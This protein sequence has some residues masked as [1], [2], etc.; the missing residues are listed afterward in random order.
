MKSR[1]VSAFLA[2]VLAA[3]AVFSAGEAHVVIMHTNDIRGHVLPSVE[4]G[5]SARLSTIVKDAKPDLMFDAGGM[6]AGSL[7]ADTFLGVPV[8]DVM[9]AIGYDAATVG[10]SDFNFGIHALAARARE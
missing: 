5:G 1:V 3:V 7:L 2:I 9:N 8:V 4:G 6:L 10:S